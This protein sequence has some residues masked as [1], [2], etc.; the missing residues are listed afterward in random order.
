MTLPV[1]GG[2]GLGRLLAGDN[3]PAEPDTY[4]PTL[5]REL[6][7]AF[8]SGLRERARTELPQFLG[9]GDLAAP[10][11]TL[12]DIE[13]RLSDAPLALQVE[14][15]A[16]GGIAVDVV[17][18][19]NT[20]IATCTTPTPLGSD[21]DPRFSLDFGLQLRFVLDVPWRVGRLSVRDVAVARV[22]A[23]D[24]DSQNFVADVVRFLDDVVEFFTGDSVVATLQNWL[25]A[26]DFSSVVEAALEPLNTRLDQLAADG[27]WQLDSWLDRLDGNPTGVAPRALTFVDAPADRLDLVLAARGWRLDGVVEGVVAWPREL[28][29]PV[30]EGV[31]DPVRQLDVSAVVALPSRVVAVADMVP[32]VQSLL[33]QPVRRGSDPASRSTVARTEVAHLGPAVEALAATEPASRDTLLTQVRAGAAT[34]VVQ[35]VGGLDR[36]RLL[37]DSFRRTT[38]DLVVFTDL[39][40]GGPP[41][42]FGTTRRV[43]TEMTAWQDDEGDECRRRYVAR[44]LPVGVPFRPQVALAPGYR[45][46]GASGITEIAGEPDGWRGEVLVR[47]ESERPTVDLS[48]QVVDVREPSGHL[49]RV[50]ADDLV[51][52]GLSATEVRQPG[53]TV[54]G[55]SSRL[56]QVALNPQPLPP[57]ESA[58]SPVLGG[59]GALRSRTGISRSSSRGD[60]GVAVASASE[61]ARQVDLTAVL[62]RVR[63]SPTGYGRVEGIDFVLA[64][65]TPPIVR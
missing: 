17:T 48:L 7:D 65:Y 59:L 25:A 36:F 61:A 22:L 55:L 58:S 54:A 44:G 26:Q 14:E 10:G 21:F 43:T 34:S 23:P 2:I 60:S 30:R 42:S 12:Y 45:W 19:R 51:A 64:P 27:F 52:A 16:G 33:A 15:T 38:D 35:I 4:F 20:V 57:K 63:E 1:A 56:E 53:L 37:V 13:V 32:A 11:V 24:L 41:G 29:R 28:G 40:A 46:S 62:E 3:G 31:V 18:G 47:P 9:R 8:W 50:L 39:A 49:R 6:A 5:L